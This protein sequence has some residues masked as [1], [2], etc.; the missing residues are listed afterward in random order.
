MLVLPE[1]EEEDVVVVV[2]D[3]FF[4][5]PPVD[6]P[7]PRVRMLLSPKRRFHESDRWSFVFELALFL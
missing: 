1:V 7:P 4:P 3:L 2:L 6:E 5:P